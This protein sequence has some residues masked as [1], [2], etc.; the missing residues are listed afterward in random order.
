MTIK[1]LAYSAQQSLQARTGSSFKRAHIYELL[2]ASYGFNSYAAL[3]TTAVFTRRP[4]D[5]HMAVPDN[6][7]VRR[8]CV[9]LGYETHTADLVASVLP[10]FLAERQIG[11]VKFSDLVAELRGESFDQDDDFDEDDSFDDHQDDLGAI[12]W[13]N[14]GDEPVSSITLEGLEIAASKNIALAHYALA[15]LHS[16]DDEEQER[17]SSYW[18]AQALQGHILTGVEKEW[19]DAHAAYLAKTA[20]YV[21]HLREAARLG[22]QYALLDLA[23]Q[24]DEPAFFEQEKS[25]VDTDPIVIADIAER[26]GRHADARS[27]LVAAAEAGDTDAIRRLIEDYDYGDLQKCWTWLYLAELHG[28]DLTQDDYHAIHEDGSSYDDD[29]GGN[30]FV[31]GCG[32]VEIGSISAEQTDAARQA[33]LAIFVRTQGPD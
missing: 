10:A 15:L 3:S 12:S 31:G 4:A 2:A 8:R 33:A 20:Q 30:M 14:S 27:W 18:H 29:A 13:G 17:G 6:V 23:E 25:P 9:A 28:T 22:Q 32:G 26:L 19:A 7:G 11:T 1:E 21:H 24:F 16:T 5:K